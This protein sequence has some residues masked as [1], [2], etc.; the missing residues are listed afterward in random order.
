MY[1]QAQTCVLHTHAFAYTHTSTCTRIR[2]VSLFVLRACV[3]CVSVCRRALVYAR[4]RMR[5]CVCL[6]A[7]VYVSDSAPDAS[8]LIVHG[9]VAS[10][11]RDLQ[12]L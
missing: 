3:M 4:V 9:R 12:L 1:T 8:M 11:T 7:Y 5:M 10:V 2:H 6:C